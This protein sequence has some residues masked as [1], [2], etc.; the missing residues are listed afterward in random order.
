MNKHLHLHPNTSYYYYKMR[1]SKRQNVF[2][3]LK[4]YHTL[5]NGNKKQFFL[6]RYIL[7]RKSNGLVSRT[8]NLEQK[9]VFK[10]EINKDLTLIVIII[11]ID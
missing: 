9:S 2:L 11:N 10:L 3:D 8:F 7:L 4:Q 5:E 1:I 6:L